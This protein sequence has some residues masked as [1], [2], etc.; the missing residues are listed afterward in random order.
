MSINAENDLFARFANM[1]SIPSKE[2]IILGV[3]PKVILSPAHV[4][5]ISAILAFASAE[6][7]AVIPRGAGTQ[8]TIGSAPQ[9]AD[10]LLDL[11]RLNAIVAYEP[12]DMTITA[13]AGA[14]I[15]SIQRAAA[16]YRQFLAIDPD[17]ADSA[18]IGGIAAVG[19]N[20]TRRMKYGGVYDQI[21]G[22]Q[23][24]L[25]DGS[26]AR[27]GGRIVKNVAGY[28][29]ARLLCGSL[30]TLAI[31]TEMTFRLQ[32]KP[33]FTRWI[34]VP[35]SSLEAARAVVQLIRASQL[36]P[37]AI[38]VLPA[39]DGFVTA[40]LFEY[41]A[42]AIQEQVAALRQLLGKEYGAWY[43]AKPVF[44]LP[45]A[46]FSLRISAPPSQTF[47]ILQKTLAAAEGMN[48]SWVA[49]AGYGAIECSAATDPEAILQMVG[50]LRPICEAA[51]G[52]LVVSGDGLSALPT[53]DPWG[54][55]GSAPL[56]RSVKSY[57]DPK[58]IL[59]PGRF[60]GGI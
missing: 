25:A 32:P 11:S 22:A 17:A 56:M 10:I 18:T 1:L 5:Q 36:S 52:A 59:N 29:I 24:V 7:L 8:M 23:F 21:L 2:D 37:S 54:T 33:P 34:G 4:D 57:Y 42:A 51:G 50:R 53:L 28:D 39:V 19:V 38:E 31:I 35:T 45:K 43:I 6:N 58:S 44:S 16:E 26:I 15:E 46:T 47:P 13:Q 30:G 40:L 27:A 60:V 55:V 12:G 3:A 20:G 14:S 9:R 48:I 49:H 41:T